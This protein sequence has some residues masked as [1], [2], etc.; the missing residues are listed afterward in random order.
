MLEDLRGPM[1]SISD[2]TDLLL[3]ESIGILGAAQQ[4]V[5]NMVAADIARLAEK[6]AEIQKVARLD[7]RPFTLEYGRIDLISLIEDVIEE[8][9]AGYCGERSN[10]RIG[11]WRSAAAGQGRWRQPQTCLRRTRSERLHGLPRRIDN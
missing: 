3:A 5:L 1:T 10:G 8:A 11:A 9:V 2:Y 7:V 6:I 4:Q